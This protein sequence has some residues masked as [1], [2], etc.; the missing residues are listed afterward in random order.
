MLVDAIDL[1]RLA[2]TVRHFQEARSIRKGGDSLARV[3]SGLQEAGTHLKGRT[4]TGHALDGIR[5]DSGNRMI[6]WGATG[7]AFLQDLNIEDDSPPSIA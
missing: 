3:P 6:L 5:Q 1:D 2:G 7:V 4:H